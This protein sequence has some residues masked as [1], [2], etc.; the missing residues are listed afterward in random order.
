M[1]VVFAIFIILLFIVLYNTLLWLKKREQHLTDADELGDYGEI[2]E[3]LKDPFKEITKGFKKIPDGFK[4]AGKEVSG[5]FKKIGN[6]AK[7]ASNQIIN[8]VKK[9][10]TNA[11]NKVG[12]EIKKVADDAKKA[13]TGALNTVKKQTTG[14]FNKVGSEIKKIP[15]QVK[16]VAD[17]AK[18]GV[19]KLESMIKKET[20]KIFKKLKK[21][22]TGPFRQLKEVFDR[23]KCFF[24]G[25]GDVFIA[26]GNYFIC[27]VEKLVNVPS[28]FI[29]YVLDIIYN[30]F[31]GIV[32]F[33]TY[34]I[35][36]L[37]PI[38]KKLYGVMMQIDSAAYKSSGF[39]IF[40]FQENILDRCYRCKGLKPIP[41]IAERCF[42]KKKKEQGVKKSSDYCGIGAPG[43]A[44]K[45]CA[46][47]KH[48]AVSLPAAANSVKGSA[49]EIK[50]ELEEKVTQSKTGSSIMS[51][52][53]DMKT[54]LQEKVSSSTPTKTITEE[55]IA[56]RC[57]CALNPK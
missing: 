33:F 48:T 27:G 15:K 56:K 57:P 13:T 53:G 38:T 34:I 31:S 42:S 50:T 10:T 22:I 17:E 35:P 16:K 47:L 41:N 5:G 6:E 3:G 12:G 25:I 19:K 45:A 24:T 54:A 46:A 43:T 9:E 36:P 52:M 2:R 30:I 11:F 21:E 4:K 7:K 44:K 37:K 26:I 1:V 20:D 29:Y 18:K 28:C 39:H 23:I 14:A 49:G 51:K 8:T 55:E 40:R 32:S